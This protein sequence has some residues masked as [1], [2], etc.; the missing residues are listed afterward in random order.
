MA[1]TNED[2]EAV[3]TNLNDAVDV[4]REMD[5]PTADRF[6]DDIEGIVTQIEEEADWDIDGEE[7]EPADWEDEEADTSDEA[8]DWETEDDDVD[9]DEYYDEEEEEDEDF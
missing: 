8:A 9:S 3:L 2:V 1:V 5:D 4:L 7:D 6:A